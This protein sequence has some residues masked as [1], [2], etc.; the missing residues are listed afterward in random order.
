VKRQIALAGILVFAFMPLLSAGDEN[1]KIHINS[2]GMKLI[3]IEPG[4][5]TMGFEEKVPDETVTFSRPGRSV[6]DI[7]PPAL[8]E[9]LRVRFGG[10]PFSTVVTRVTREFRR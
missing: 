4:A 6:G 3:R 9:G 10:R 2:V 7:K 8:W 1:Q 5:F